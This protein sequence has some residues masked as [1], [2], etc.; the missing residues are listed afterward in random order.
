[1]IH[2]INNIVKYQH[3]WTSKQSKSTLCQLS[4]QLFCPRVESMYKCYNKVHDSNTQHDLWKK[5]IFGDVEVI[6]NHK[7][8][9]S[10]VI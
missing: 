10:D 9:N 8:N 7:I 2:T 5:V 1:M 3:L 4:R 6:Q